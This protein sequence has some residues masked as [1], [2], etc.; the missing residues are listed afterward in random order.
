MGAEDAR[1]RKTRARGV[2]AARA[3]R[4]LWSRGAWSGADA[5]RAAD[6]DD[7]VDAGAR[8]LG[9]GARDVD[10]NR[11]GVHVHGAE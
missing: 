9:H 5:V 4:V 3:R 11:S 8:G 6:G 2:R 10:E 7:G 1:A